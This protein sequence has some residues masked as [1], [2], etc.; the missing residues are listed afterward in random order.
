MATD[1]SI[2]DILL[3]HAVDMASFATDAYPFTIS[4]LGVAVGR[5][6]AAKGN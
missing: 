5:V 2:N 1:A 3:C 4:K 6:K